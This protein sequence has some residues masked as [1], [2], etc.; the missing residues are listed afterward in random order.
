VVLVERTVTRLQ[1]AGGTDSDKGLG[2][3]ARLLFGT[4]PAVLLAFLSLIS[5]SW[6]G[7]GFEADTAAQLLRD[8]PWVV[9]AGLTGAGAGG[10]LAWV[11]V[12]GR[13]WA[14]AVGAALGT[15]PAAVMV[16]AY[17]TDAY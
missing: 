14:V 11:V 16:T 3:I 1:A 2:T 12:G 17:F 8:A 4:P 6:T 15:F 7:W 10:V 5:L 9:I 13:V